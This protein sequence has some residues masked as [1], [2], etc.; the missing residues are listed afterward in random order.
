MREARECHLEGDGAQYTPNMLTMKH[1][2]FV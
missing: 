2:M 1:T